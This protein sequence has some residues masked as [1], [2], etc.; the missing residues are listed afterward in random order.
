MRTIIENMSR[1][2]NIRNL[3]CGRCSSEI[4]NAL[5][6]LLVACKAKTALLNILAYRRRSEFQHY[7]TK[8]DK[9]LLLRWLLEPLGIILVMVIIII[10]E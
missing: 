10:V 6:G 2:A 9:R 7:Y 4:E 1:T 5:H 3:I 8:V